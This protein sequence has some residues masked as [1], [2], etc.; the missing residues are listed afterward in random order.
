[1]KLKIIVLI[2]IIIIDKQKD[3]K[4]LR[5]IKERLILVF[6]NFNLITELIKYYL[7]CKRYIISAEFQIQRRLL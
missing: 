4:K 3:I 6:N 1:M 7:F 5:N 2:L